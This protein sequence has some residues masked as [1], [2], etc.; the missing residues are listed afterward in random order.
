MMRSPGYARSSDTDA[1]AHA[2]SLATSLLRK[3]PDHDMAQATQVCDFIV[4]WFA[5]TGAAENDATLGLIELNAKFHVAVSVFSG[6]S[7]PPQQFHSAAMKPLD[8]PIDIGWALNVGNVCGLWWGWSCVGG[9]NVFFCTALHTT[10]PPCPSQWRIKASFGIL[11]NINRYSTTAHA[12]T[13]N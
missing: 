3:H 9:V 6:P 7:C 12:R 13:V 11:H 10:T 2:Y 1:H 4:R 5:E 8:I